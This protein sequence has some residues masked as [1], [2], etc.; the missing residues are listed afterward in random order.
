MS[1]FDDFS[2]KEVLERIM[3]AYGFKNYNLLAKQFDTSASAISS[4]L[5]RSTISTDFLV[6]CS[7]ETGVSLRWLLSGK[8]NSEAPQFLQASKSSEPLKVQ[9]HTKIK[10]LNHGILTDGGDVQIEVE[11]LKGIAK[12]FIVSIAESI[13]ILDA[14][15]KQVTNG[16]WLLNVVN[17][18]GIYDVVYTSATTVA[19]SGGEYVPPRE[20]S[21]DCLSFIARVKAIYTRL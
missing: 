16:K 17:N 5:S 13:F 15:F 12:P 18:T 1:F 7:I 6:Q 9:K 8:P 20:F 3:E 10:I 11:L 21:V 19:V 2:P 14:E 4:R